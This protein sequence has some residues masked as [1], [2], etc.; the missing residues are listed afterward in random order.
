MSTAAYEPEPGG[1]NADT[2][3][4]QGPGTQIW[5]IFAPREFGFAQDPSTQGPER[6][7]S[8]QGGPIASQL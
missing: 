4:L 1:P 5:A 8:Q 7:A 6:L 2:Y 3:Q